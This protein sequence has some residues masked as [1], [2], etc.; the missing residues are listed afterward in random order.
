MS[1][2][3]ARLVFWDAM[4]NAHTLVNRDGALMSCIR[5]RGPDLHSAMASAL[6]V[7]AEQLNNCF[8][9][10][11]GGWGVLSEARRRE[12]RTYPASTWTHPAARLVDEERRARFLTPGLHYQ[13]DCTLTL[14]QRQAPKLAGAWKHLLYEGLPKAVPLPGLTAFEEQVRRTVALLGEAC[15]EVILLEDSALLTYLHSTVS[16]KAYTVAVPDPPAYLDTYLSRDATIA[17]VW[18][19]PS[20][21][22]YPTLN[23]QHLRCV[24][25]LAYPKQTEPGLLDVL[26]TLPLEYRATVRYLPLS[27]QAAIRA[28]Q[29]AGD[30]YWGQ[31]HRGT[32]TRTEKASMTRAEDAST[33]QEG[34]ELD[35]WMAGYVTQTIVVW[36]ATPEG[37][38]AKAETIEA[39]LN[40]AGFTAKV[41]GTNTLP[42][43]DGSLPGNRTRNLST[44]ML[45]TRNLSHL[46]PATS[47]VRGP[48]WNK[49][50]DGPPL[51]MVTGRG[52]TP[53]ALDL[54]D[55]DV[56]HTF[57]VGPPGTGKSTLVANLALAW[58]KYRGAQVYAIDKDQSLRCA[59]YAV[60]G[61]WYDIGAE[62]TAQTQGSAA[63]MDDPGF[64]A[65]GAL[66]TP[67]PGWWQCYE[68]ASL[69]T[70]PT[71]IPQ[72]MGPLLRQMEERLTGVPTL[73][74]LDEAWVYLRNE[75]LRG[76]IQ[77]YLLTLRKKN[78]VVIFSTQ[79]LEHLIG[80]EIGSDVYQ[81]CV[82]KIFL[83]NAQALTPH[84][85]KLY[86]DLGLTERECYLI[87]TLASKRQYLVMGPH[88]RY[89]MDL[90]MGKVGLAYTGVGRKEDLAA[91]AE[92]YGRSRA[93]FAHNWLVYKGL[94]DAAARLHEGDNDE[95]NADLWPA[96]AHALA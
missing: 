73:I 15:E 56:A 49:H 39:T 30:S 10:L 65:W 13:T 33:F 69:L 79:N 72:V 64:Q 66:W 59:T 54:H 86:R 89:V 88:G 19:L 68:M 47:H 31:R 44:T 87:A 27:R 96:A 62:L 12:V 48:A 93:D 8:K 29:A 2:P 52:Q 18:A 1:T 45:T 3:V 91:I 25:A 21:I 34:I 84:V 6:L 35:A 42:A 23:G 53:V 61:D 51:L 70:T 28:A 22:Q 16:W 71:I 75:F 17:Y 37:A 94:H 74:V 9:R 36:D 50:L 76:K 5:F 41:E 58:L 11:S 32:N 90:G 46:V 7:Q 78:G 24:S 40:T 95:E 4:A 26:D 63:S 82:T 85:G 81:S 14:T 67:P 60:G 20:L 92:V 80:S 38:I 77:D 83:A 43:W 55:D 57:I